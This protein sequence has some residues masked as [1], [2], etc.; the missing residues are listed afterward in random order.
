MSGLRLGT[1]TK[2]ESEQSSAYWSAVHYAKGDL[3]NAAAR[4]IDGLESGEGSPYARLEE[5][6]SKLRH[7]LK[8]LEGKW[9]KYY[10]REDGDWYIERVDG[11]RF[12]LAGNVWLR[13]DHD[14]E[15]KPT[16]VPWSDASWLIEG[17]EHKTK[18]H[19]R[20]IFWTDSKELANALADKLGKLAA[21]SSFKF[22][23]VDSQVSS[24]PLT[25]SYAVLVA[26]RMDWVW[27]G[28]VENAARE[29]ATKLEA[30][31][32]AGA[33]KRVQQ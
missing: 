19:G 14:G 12:D 27:R 13:F 11:G 8:E 26:G 21:F 20:V 28:M 6:I 32:Q 24:S 23:A 22:S 29:I 33:T 30:E 31:H 10:D 17:D 16:H 25:W 18:A 15:I 9:V 4:V 1:V 2:S 7:E 3:K 5:A